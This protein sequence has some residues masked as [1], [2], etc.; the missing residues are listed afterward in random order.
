VHH[1][2][3]DIRRQGAPVADGHARRDDAVAGDPATVQHVQLGHGYQPDGHRRTV[4]RQDPQ[5]LHALVPLP[6]LQPPS[7]PE[8]RPTGVRPV[9]HPGHDAHVRAA[10]LPE[11]R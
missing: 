11:P 9:R 6:L 7:S 5:F 2:A 4:H 8:G 10:R 1:L 3:A